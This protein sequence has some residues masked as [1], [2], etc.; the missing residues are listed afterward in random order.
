MSETQEKLNAEAA[1]SIVYAKDLTV[2]AHLPVV[3][4]EAF[5]LGI[6]LLATYFGLWE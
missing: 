6:L 4:P 3:H 5:A 1:R 2:A